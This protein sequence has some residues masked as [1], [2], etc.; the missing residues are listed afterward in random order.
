MIWL[1]VN[2]EMNVE[3]TKKYEVTFKV[4]LNDEPSSTEWA[5]IPLYVMARRGKKREYCWKKVE[6]KAAKES[7]IPEDEAGRGLVI[8][9]VTSNDDED[10]TL[11]FGLYDIWS[12]KLKEGLAI[13]HARVLEIP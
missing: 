1:E 5:K 6:L 3:P 11:Y 12:G 10:K 9:K 2:G 8:D 7:Y 4:S 13:H